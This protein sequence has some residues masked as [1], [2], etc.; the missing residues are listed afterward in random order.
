MTSHN[1]AIKTELAINNLQNRTKVKLSHA[2]DLLLPKWEPRSI[3]QN[4]TT[5][6][7]RPNGMPVTMLRPSD[8]LIPAIH[9]YD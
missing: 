8:T 4:N 7:L 1:K 2:I 5:I 6:V 9:N 3:M